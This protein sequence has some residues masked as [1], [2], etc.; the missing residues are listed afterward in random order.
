MN[1]LETLDRRFKS[2]TYYFSHKETISDVNPR[3]ARASL[4]SSLAS[5][6]TSVEEE[7]RAL[8]AISWLME[9]ILTIRSKAIMNACNW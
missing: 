6:A 7:D 2:L 4:R 5:Y 3:E 9:D 8:E 1:A